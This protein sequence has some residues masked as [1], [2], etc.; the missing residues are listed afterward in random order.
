M[1]RTDQYQ[2]ILDELAN[3]ELDELQVK[4][5]HFL[6]RVYPAPLTRRELIECIYG[7]RPADDEDLNNN[8]NDRKIRAA[9]AGMF[10]LDYPIS[11]TS[12]GAGYRIDI[13]T[14]SWSELVNELE[15]KKKTL[16]KKIEAAIRISAR[17]RKS[18][19]NAI[20]ST[21]PVYNAPA[22]AAAKKQRQLSFLTDGAS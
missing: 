3:G 17:I 15:S 14:E 6:R 10:E 2:R 12:G 4:V 19:R 20:P 1:A 11:S 18:G 5:F 13:D 22:P 7:N 8:T 21:A 16:E 9:I